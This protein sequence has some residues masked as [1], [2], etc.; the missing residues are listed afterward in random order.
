MKDVFRTQTT[1]LLPLYP[2]PS[3]SNM[4]Q[5]RSVDVVQLG[6]LAAIM[7]LTHTVTH[8]HTQV[9]TWLQT[10]SHQVG[11]T[12]TDACACVTPL[13]KKEK[14]LYFNHQLV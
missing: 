13:L 12:Q 4:L 5:N 10:G 7:L 1:C 14:L 11:K 2:H 8:K 9:S 6:K 3:I